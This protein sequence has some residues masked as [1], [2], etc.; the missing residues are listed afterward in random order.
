MSDYTLIQSV[1][2]Y[3][4]PET[5]DF[6]L[7]CINGTSLKGTI[8]EYV[9]YKYKEGKFIRY[10]PNAFEP[11]RKEIWRIED[12]DVS[13]EEMLS[14]IKEECSKLLEDR[15]Q[16]VLWSLKKAKEFA[17]EVNAL[18]DLREILEEKF[19]WNSYQIQNEDY[20]FEL[21]NG[22][23]LIITPA[24]DISIEDVWGVDVNHW[25]RIN[26]PLVTN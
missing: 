10:S 3:Y 12:K 6:K 22:C 9:N 15:K 11:K 13:Y 20:L 26:K 2:I 19:S 16:T 24:L 23:R 7:N 14:A 21:S 1:R 18:N 5:D 4:V 25:L 8:E 17:S